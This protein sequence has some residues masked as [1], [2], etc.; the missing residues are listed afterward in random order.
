[1]DRRHEDHQQVQQRQV[2]VTRTIARN[3]SREHVGDEKHVALV[4]ASTKTPA[5]A[6]RRSPDEEAQQE[7]AHGR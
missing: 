6:R 5:I 2:A 7:G 4:H 1:V 3:A